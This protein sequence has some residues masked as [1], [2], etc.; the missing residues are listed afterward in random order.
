M[1]E[2]L[3]LPA[4]E[5]SENILTGISEMINKLYELFCTYEN[6]IDFKEM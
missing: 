1:E 5:D 3:K 4:D 6:D 2:A